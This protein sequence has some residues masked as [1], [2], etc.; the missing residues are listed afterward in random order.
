MRKFLGMLAAILLLLSLNGCSTTSLLVKGPAV[1]PS[2]SLAL[3]LATFEIPKV[4]V[5]YPHVFYD[6]NDWRKHIQTLIESAKDYVVISSF[7]AS[8]SDSLQPFFETLARKAEEGVRVYFIADGIGAFD[9]TDTRFHLIPLQFLRERGVH[10]LEYNPITA[11][12]IVGGAKLFFRDHRKYIIIDGKQLAMGGMNLN[13]ISI[14]S[15]DATLQRDTMYEFYSPELVSILLDGFV[16][17]WNR[18]SWDEVKRED[19]SVDWQASEGED[20]YDAWFVDQHPG[21]Q[22]LSG[23]YGSLLSESKA[24][25]KVLPFLPFFD[26]N[27]IAAFAKAK[28]RGVDVEMIIPFDQRETNRKGIEYMAKDLLKMDIDLRIEREG[29][30]S[31]RLLHEK[32]MIVDSR[33]VVIGSANVNFRSLNL[34][35]ELALVVDCPP[36]AVQVEGHFKELYQM[37]VP[38]TENMAD[39]WRTFDS[40]PRYMFGVIGG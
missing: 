15:S 40:L 16:D 3:K 30:S 13:Y 5:T 37:T 27:M 19:F 17:F 29:E 2:L 20:L 8:S 9:M 34:A 22:Q 39:E 21:S 33:Y 32:L 38:I 11:G 10:M 4:Q 23:L 25:I 36:L 26:N 14:G 18:N 6:G 12:R 24:S 28:D 7:L 1:D 35:N 31:K